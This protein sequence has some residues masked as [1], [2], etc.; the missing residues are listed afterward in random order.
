MSKQLIIRTDA[1]ADMTEAA[2]WYEEQGQ[3][4][5]RDFLEKLDAL[6]G[7]I[8]DNPELFPIVHRGARLAPLKRFPYLVIYKDFTEHISEAAVVHGARDPLHWRGRLD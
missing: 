2:L 5:G 3:G 8:S 4:L 7:L 1:H 6:F